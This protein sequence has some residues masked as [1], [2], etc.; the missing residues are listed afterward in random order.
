[1]L[2]QFCVNC[3]LFFGAVNQTL[4]G[5]TKFKTFRDNFGLSN[6]K[7]I[8]LNHAFPYVY[9]TLEFGILK[10]EWQAT[11]NVS[12]EK[13]LPTKR[14]GSRYIKC[15]VLHI[16]F[17]TYIPT[18]SNLYK[19]QNNYLPNIQY[20]H[21]KSI[22]LQILSSVTPNLRKTPCSKHHYL[23]LRDQKGGK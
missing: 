19:S 22:N 15:G 13:N 9:I 17:C 4:F 12:Q 21:Q 6:V 18:Y 8:E 11:L 3:G 14:L 10:F 1:M 7:Q 16:Y 20:E 2:L 5:G 23:K